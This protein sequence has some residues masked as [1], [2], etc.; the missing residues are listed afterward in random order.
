MLNLVINMTHHYKFFNGL[1][2]IIMLDWLII[3]SLKNQFDE[4]SF[5]PLPVVPYV[6]VAADADAAAVPLAVD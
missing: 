1:L 6:V 4:N 5:I 3:I 2:M